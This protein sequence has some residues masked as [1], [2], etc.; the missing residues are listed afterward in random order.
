[1]KWS[2]GRFLHRRVKSEERWITL[3]AHASLRLGPIGHKNSLV[4]RGVDIPF[5]SH[6]TRLVSVDLILEAADGAAVASDHRAGHMRGLFRA[7][8]YHGPRR[9]IPGRYD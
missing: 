1:M 7:E 5:F 9:G 4:L 6:D 2:G 3:S 8:E